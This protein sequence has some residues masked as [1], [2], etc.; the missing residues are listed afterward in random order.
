MTTRR[1]PRDGTILPHWFL[2]PVLHVHIHLSELWFG[3]GANI[4]INGSAQIMSHPTTSAFRDSTDRQL[5]TLILSCDLQESAPY[6]SEK[7]MW[8][9]SSVS[10]LTD[11]ACASNEDADMR[12]L[13]SMTRMRTCESGSQTRRVGN[14]HMNKFSAFVNSVTVS[15]S[16]RFA[17]SS[18]RGARA[19]FGLLFGCNS[20]PT[21]N[22]PGVAG[23]QALTPGITNYPMAYVKQPVLAANTNKK[24]KA[25]TPTDIDARDLITSITGSDLYVREHGERREPRGQRHACPSPTARARCAISTS[26]PTA[27]RSSSRCA[28]RSTPTLANT[29]P[30]QP[31][32]KIYQYDAK[33][34]TVTQLTN[35]R[36][37]RR[38]RR[39]R[40]LPARR[41]HRVRLD[42][43][44]G[45]AGDPARRGTPA[46][47]GGDHR[48][49]AGHLPAARH[50]RRR[51]RH[52][53]DQL[54]HQP[55]LRAL[56]ARE[57][58]DRVLA[59]GVPTNGDQISLYVTN[60]G[61]HG[62][63]SSTTAPTATPPAPT[64]PAPT[65][66]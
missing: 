36:R 13:S 19:A 59:L 38:P 65:T 10:A 46:I 37:H 22:A 51:H 60:P 41:T 57:R 61:R 32:W 34:K 4:S 44:A 31:N 25:A 24:D 58:P 20:A 18:G 1:A 2:H 17:E 43:P 49:A 6:C 26:R 9:S 39:R 48:S 62:R 45:D 55:R 47:P 30:K 53:S 5:R 21:G 40:P 16:A 23:G 14:R 28:C 27:P 35:D 54:Q 3:P 12:S 52:A 33:A 42:A 66:T 11:C 50:E 8:R 56:G 15:H 63:C 7:R 29:D 64:S